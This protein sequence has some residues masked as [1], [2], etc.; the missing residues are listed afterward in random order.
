MWGY[1]IYRSTM[2]HLQ[3]IPCKEIQDI[4]VCGEKYKKLTEK[5]ISLENLM[6]IAP[7]FF[8][9]EIKFTNVCRKFL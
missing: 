9:K 7:N 3:V 8:R 4:F 5:P 6:R 1:A 2:K